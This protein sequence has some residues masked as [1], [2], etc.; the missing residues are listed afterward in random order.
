MKVREL[1]KQD[2]SI[3]VYDDVC[4]E[5]GIAFEGPQGLTEEGK[6]HF[7]EVLDYE[8][9]LHNDGRYLVGIVKIDDPED[10]VWESRLEKAKEFFESAAGYCSC[11]DYD[12]WFKED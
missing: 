8:V 11:S 2:V 7:E 3:D 9:E 6:E 5:L 12:R 10:E 1:I 4:E